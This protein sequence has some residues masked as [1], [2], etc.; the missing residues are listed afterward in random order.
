MRLKVKLLDWSAGIPVAVLNEKIAKRMGVHA[1][2]RISVKIGSSPKKDFSV[3]VDIVKRLVPQ[4]QIGVSEELAKRLKLRKNQVVDVNLAESASGIYAIKKK[5]QN[6]TLSPNEIRDVIQ[7]ATDNSLSDAEIALF[8]AGM[9]K[10]GMEFKETIELIDS[11][12]ASGKK[13]K[14]R[15]KIIVDKHCIGGIPGNRT[16][17]IIVAICAA[18]GLTFPKSSSRAITSAAGTADVIEAIANIDFSLDEIKKIIRKTNACLV[19]GGSV[20]IVPAD[21]RIIKIEKL[22]KIDP[23]AMLLAS[24]MS[25]KIAMGAEYILIDI[26]YGENAKVSKHK[27]ADLKNKFE[28]LGKHFKKKLKVVLTDGNAPIGRGVGPV[29][30]L[31]DVLSVLNPTKE[32]PEDLEKKSIMLAGEI[33][34]MTKTAKK[35]EGKKLARGIIYSGKALEKFQQIIHVQHGS[36]KNL[37]LGPHKKIINSSKSGKINFIDNKKIASLA[38]AAGCPIDKMSGVYL[39]KTVKEQVKRGEPLVTIY[40]ETKSRLIEAVKFYK[41]HKIFSIS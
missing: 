9:Y 17:P 4:T 18:A 41:K 36:L 33:F 28:K 7:E 16:T 13:L 23:E 40:A 6:K 8:I 12:L 39:E 26:P 30:E 21:S 22:L 2:N 29:L 24:V 3:V 37:Y 11:I 31:V 5:F 1:G 15:N 14:L 35:G 10:Y 27:A 32:G 19:W 20:G 34:E 38:R 25:K